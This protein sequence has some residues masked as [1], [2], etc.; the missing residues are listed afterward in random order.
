[1]V[2]GIVDL[3]TTGLSARADAILEIGL[4]VQRDGCTLERFS[5]LVRTDAPVPAVITALTGIE[6]AHLDGAPGLAEALA[7]MA[8]VLRAHGVEALVAHNARF[9]RGFLELAWRAHASG[10]PLPQFLCSLRLARRLVRARSYALGALVE[11]LGIPPAARHRALGDAEMTAH[12]WRELLARARLD[13][14]H[15]LEALR[16]LGRSAVRRRMRRPS[17]AVDAPP[18]IR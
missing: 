15:T 9:D 16:R 1:M 11:Q 18:G 4:V 14:I 2:F 13:G 12:L 7:R 5:T 17:R 10:S 6:S 3:E 8:Q